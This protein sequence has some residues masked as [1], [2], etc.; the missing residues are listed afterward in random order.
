MQKSLGKLYLIF[1]LFCLILTLFFGVMAAHS[2][3]IPGFWKDLLG[4]QQLRPIHASSALF[5]ILVSANGLVIHFQTKS[6]NKW[7]D[8]FAL[9][10]LAI[11][12]VSMIIAYVKQ[13]FGGREYWEAGWPFSSLVLAAFVL[14]FINGL[15]FFIGTKPRKVYHWMWLSGSSF[16]VLCMAENFLWLI[17]GIHADTVKDLTLQWKANGAFVGAWNQLIYGVSFQLMEK[18]GGKDAVVESKTAYGMFFLGLFNLIFNWG[19]HVYL[20]PTYAYV[21]FIGY[22]V[23][24][25]EWIFF[26]RIFTDWKKSLPAEL[27]KLRKQEGTYWFLVASETWIMLNM[28]LA[29]L[30]SIPAINLYTHG[31]HITVAHSMGATIG[32]NSMILLGGIWF[33]AFGNKPM[34]K[35]NRFWFWLSQSSLLVLWLS[36]L[37]AGIIKSIWNSEGQKHAFAF[38]MQQSGIAFK[39]FA[40][41]GSLLMLALGAIGIQLLLKLIKTEPKLN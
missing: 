13:D 20:V 29:I 15:R 30:M 39:L 3:I 11:A 10:L 23:S 21:K 22:T 33:M 7:I 27:F 2:Y 32:I 9:A 19:H 14:L 8:N 40:W 34:S 17:P 37:M 35:W 25:T 6:R 38:M 24:M 12:Y 18:I 1:G 41:S 26:I 16:L 36:L 5:W 4:F 31:T 28:G